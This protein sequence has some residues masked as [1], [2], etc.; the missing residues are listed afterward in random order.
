MR[1]SKKILT[2]NIFNSKMLEALLLDWE[3]EKEVCYHRFYSTWLGN[4][5]S[6]VKEQEIKGIRLGDGGRNKSMIIYR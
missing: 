6:E 1:A 4:L 5:T 3:E 2:E